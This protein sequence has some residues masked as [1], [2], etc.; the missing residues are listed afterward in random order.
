MKIKLTNNIKMSEKLSYTIDELV[1]EPWNEMIV[2][3]LNEI[4]KQDIINHKRLVKKE[5]SFRKGN[6]WEK[7]SHDK[8]QLL[9][10]FKGKLTHRANNKIY[11]QNPNDLLI[12]PKDLPHIAY[13]DED[14]ALYWFTKK[15]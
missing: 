7:H 1:K 11:V 14:L 3:S 12:V 6:E 5:Y 13:A 2:Y 10:V 4:Q 15:E 8:P 9:L